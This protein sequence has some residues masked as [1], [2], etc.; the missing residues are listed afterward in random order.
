VK[1]VRTAHEAFL[2]R[3]NPVDPEWDNGVF[4]RFKYPVLT[5]RH[6]PIEWRYDLNP[7]TN[8]F[9]MERLPNLKTPVCHL[10]VH[11]LPQGFQRKSSPAPAAISWRRTRARAS[12]PSRTGGSATAGCDEGV[13]SPTH[14][15]HHAAD[16]SALI[17][18][19]FVHVCDDFLEGGALSPPGVVRR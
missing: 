12:A 1:A 4:E 7:A 13:A 18:V 5:A 11:D 19:H 16:I 14:S 2:N 15:P 17:S 10:P 3:K 8:P 9:F 6:A